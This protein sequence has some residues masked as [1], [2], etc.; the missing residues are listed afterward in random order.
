MITPP[1][2]RYLTILCEFMAF[3]HEKVKP[4]PKD[5]EFSEDELAAITPNDILKW[6]NVKAFGTPTPTSQ[7]KLTGSFS[8]LEFMKKALS[9]YM[10]HKENWDSVAAVV[11]NRVDG[12]VSGSGCGGSG[13]GRGNPTKSREVKALMQRIVALG[14]GEKRKN[15]KDFDDSTTTAAS[16]DNNYIYG[17]SLSSSTAGDGGPHG[18]LRR[19]QAQNNDYITILDTMGMA[20]R[21]FGRSVQQMKMALETNNI[22]IRHELSKNYG[23]NSNSNNNNGCNNDDNNGDNDENDDHDKEDND[24]ENTT[25]RLSSTPNIPAMNL[26]IKESTSKFND[27]IQHFST[28]NV[29]ITSITDIKIL[30]GADGFCTFHSELTG[31]QT[32]VPDGFEFPSCDLLRAWRHWIAGFPDFKMRNENSIIN[33]NNSDDDDEGVIDAPIRPLRFVNTSDLPQSLKKK[34]KDGWRPILLSMQGDVADMLQSTPV[35]EVDEKFVLETYEIAMKKLFAKAPGIC[36]E[37]GWDRYGTWKVA[38]WSRKIREQCLGQQQVRRRQEKNGSCSGSFVVLKTQEEGVQQGRQQSPSQMEEEGTTMQQQLTLKTEE[39]QAQQ[40]QQQQQSPLGM[41]EEQTPSETE[42]RQ[43]QEPSPE[44]NV[45]FKS[46]EELVHATV[47]GG[48]MV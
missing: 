14:G 37:S 8:T 4:Y 40:Q 41:E 18:L 38:T 34:F 23:D 20:L 46:T 30:S 12:D 36:A 35:S 24:M 11:E 27:I 2:P 25:P 1:S 33:S 45:Q 16:Q 6:M 9:F 29:V 13:S 39:Q 32:D 17:M 10:P 19:M 44:V 7:S 21:T 3:Y 26:E 31:K 43:T 5:H 22:T 28:S 42:D 15:R 47:A 48:S